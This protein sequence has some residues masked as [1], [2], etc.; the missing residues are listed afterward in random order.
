MGL[1][2]VVSACTD[3]TRSRPLLDEP[4]SQ[5]TTPAPTAD[6]PAV[7]GDSALA[8]ALTVVPAAAETITFTDL[9]AVKGRLGYADV[10]SDSPTS[11]RFE[12]WEEVRSDGSVFS[13]T[14]LYDASSEL[15]LDY[16]WTGEDVVWEVGFSAPETGCLESM[17]CD[18]AN[19]YAVAFRDDL[20]MRT[21]LQS[22][23]D[24]GFRPSET[25]H[26]WLAPDDEKAPF[27][28][29]V[30]V[31][32]LNA[33]AGGSPIGVTR[34]SDV[35]EGA[36]SAL[37]ELAAMVSALGSVESAYLDTT[38]C[39]TLD[40]AL[41][42]DVTEDD[43]AAYLKK[44]DL[45]RLAEVASYGVGTDGRG[46]AVTVAEVR[47]GPTKEAVQARTAVLEQWPSLQAGV[48]FSDVA[49][50][51]VEAVTEPVPGERTRLDL[52]DPPTFRSMVLTDDA[53][54][55]VCPT[56]PPG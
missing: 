22:L 28:D 3:D 11:Q 8:A 41:G 36:P 21:V 38:G 42:P 47:G 39:V 50:V 30:V 25:A 19:G 7:S 44:N 2:V 29:L 1:L 51:E 49:A 53:P 43:V 4:P 32:E 14:R 55:A 5:P 56:Q 13:G 33:L 9:T 20:S 24:N 31:P 6:V 15:S 27:G 16:G 37:G 26:V 17:I 34:I 10:T 46:G 40:E 48:D 23:Q 35:T 12:F 18:R 45:S 52:S 54:W